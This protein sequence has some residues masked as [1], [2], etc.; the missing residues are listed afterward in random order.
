MFSKPLQ[1]IQARS[2]NHLISSTVETQRMRSYSRQ[3]LWSEAGAHKS[4]PKMCQ[5]GCNWGTW[6]EPTCLL[7]KDSRPLR[8][9][10]NLGKGSIGSRVVERWEKIAWSATQST[11]THPQL[12]AMEGWQSPHQ[13]KFGLR[14][15]KRIEHSAKNRTRNQTQEGKRKGA[16]RKR[17]RSKNERKFFRALPAVE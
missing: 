12:S 3:S 4:A 8:V 14:T 13:C 17:E 6:A 10:C 1:I 11:A 16:G 7:C 2:S 9:R 15:K 5:Q